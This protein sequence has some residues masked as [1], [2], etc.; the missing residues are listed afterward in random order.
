MTAI[1]VALTALGFWLWFKPYRGEE[2]RQRMR[3]LPSHARGGP[4]KIDGGAT[5]ATG[6]MVTM[7]GVALIASN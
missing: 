7:L 4:R 1:G 5:I 2:L 3:L 6:L